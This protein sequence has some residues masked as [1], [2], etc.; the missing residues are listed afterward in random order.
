LRRDLFNPEIPP[1]ELWDVCILEGKFEVDY[2]KL[3]PPLPDG[4]HF[5]AA[6]RQAVPPEKG[7]PYL[8]GKDHAQWRWPVAW[9]PGDLWNVYRYHLSDPVPFRKS[10]RVDIEHGW[11]GNER[12]DSS[13]R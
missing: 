9:K 13:S 8:K 5:F 3:E 11:Q 10:L 1:G 7:R 12:S 6:S 2:R 4:L